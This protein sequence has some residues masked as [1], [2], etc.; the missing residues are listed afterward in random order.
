MRCVL[1]VLLLG[2]ALATCSPP[3]WPN[4]P[5]PIQA[6]CGAGV[7]ECSASYNVGGQTYK[8]EWTV[9]TIKSKSN[10]VNNYKGAIK[11]VVDNT[12]LKADGWTDSELKVLN[13][14][15][16]GESGGKAGK[17]GGVKL[18]WRRKR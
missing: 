14:N 12:D 18:V 3:G 8:V 15:M 17:L 1:V 11:G 16:M 6:T 4:P 9:K 13:A 7:T 10:C 5:G 2:V